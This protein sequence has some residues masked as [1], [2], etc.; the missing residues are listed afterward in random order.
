MAL[1]RRDTHSLLAQNFAEFAD[2]HAF[3][4]NLVG[5]AGEKGR[6]DEQQSA[7]QLNALLINWLTSMRL[8]IDHAQTR[9]TREYG[10]A[11]SELSAFRD[12]CTTAFDKSLGYRFMYKLRNYTLHCGLPLSGIDVVPRR[13]GSPI[14]WHQE[15]VFYLHRDRLLSD[16]GEWGPVYKDLQLQPLK[17]EP[18]PLVRDAM[19]ELDQIE[20]QIFRLDLSSALAGWPKVKE[21]LDRLGPQPGSPTLFRYNERDDD[22]RTISMSP[23]P[24]DRAL[25]DALES[26]DD[27]IAV[28]QARRTERRKPPII[29]AKNLHAYRRGASVISKWLSEGGPTSAFADHIE[30]VIAEDNGF[31]PLLIGVTQCSLILLNISSSVLGRSRESLIAGLLEDLPAVGGSLT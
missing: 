23:L 20:E 31:E 6:I 21:A 15:V 27:P 11:S 22:I 16:Y 29:T 19:D 30:N 4:R 17:I 9:L 18:L 10:R 13:T 26:A 25:I 28:L 5:S 7:A 1:E 24:S 8:Y 14:H 3:F 2:R 12:W